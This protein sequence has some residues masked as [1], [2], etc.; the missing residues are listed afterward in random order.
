MPI[1]KESRDQG[2]QVSAE[3]GFVRQ[4]IQES[5]DGVQPVG[6]IVDNDIQAKAEEGSVK[7]V[8]GESGGFHINVKPE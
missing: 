2:F 5:I 7:V 8:I 3:S 6:Y 4:S 1:G